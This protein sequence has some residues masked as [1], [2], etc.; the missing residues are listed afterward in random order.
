METDEELETGYGPSAP[1][2]DNL[3]NDYARGLAESFAALAEGRGDRVVRDGELALTLA[4]GGSPALFGNIAVAG[5]PLDDAGWRE[6]AARMHRFYG[7]RPG[8]SF[9]VFSAWPTPDLVPLDFGRIGHP[10][11]M[12]R[13]PAPLAVEVIDGFE[14]RAVDDGATAED[15]ERALVDGFPEPALQPVQP[16]CLLPERALGVARWRHW[17]GYLEGRPVGTA[18]AWVGDHHVDVDF[19]ATVE[20][21]RGRG[22]GRALT[23]T[24]TLARPD[25]PAMLIA[26]DLGRPVYERLGYRTILRF[27]LWAGHRRA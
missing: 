9:L 21:A 2:G 27:T 5:R 26:S 4:D 24:A 15:W 11:L 10:P 13:L 19:V 7:G 8:G 3:C 12:V 14:V 23:A 20:A 22:I 17:V 16:G 18:S 6:A 1:G 25:L